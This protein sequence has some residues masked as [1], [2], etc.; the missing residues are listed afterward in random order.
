[1]KKSLRTIIILLVVLALCV[2]G[3]VAVTKLIDKQEAKDKADAEA[4]E[5][6][7]GE[8]IDALYIGITTNAG[9][10]EF[11]N[12]G[13]SWKYYQDQD[14]PLDESYMTAIVDAAVGLTAVREIEVMDQLSY[15][16]LDE[17]SYLTLLIIDS[18]NH[19]FALDIGS[20]IGDGSTWY[21]RDPGLETIYVISGELP[22]AVDFE[23]YDMIELERF[24]SFKPTD[25]KSMTITAD[26]NKVVYQQETTTET[27]AT[28]EIDED[29]GEEI[30]MDNVIS[31]WYDLSSG[32]AVQM[33]DNTVPDSLAQIASAFEFASCMNYDA[34]EEY[35]DTAGFN[36]PAVSVT[37]TWED[38]SGKE[39]SRTM[40]IARSD[41]E[42]KY[43]AKLSDSNVVYLIDSIYV[44]SFIVVSNMS[45][46]NS[47]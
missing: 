7:I 33:A 22:A 11:V 34:S 23:L 5:I 9:S 4:S 46:S 26:E 21:A 36:D 20:P 17:G 6:K 12:D 1:M 45:A 8:I 24:G 16:G 27:V 19:V 3:F 43:W 32:E 42:G 35:L 25:I 18:E 14:F 13:E 40:V 15:Y 28:G 30:Y 2:G 38:V 37:V 39:V 29:T 44:E 31:T 41:G 10:M 47:N